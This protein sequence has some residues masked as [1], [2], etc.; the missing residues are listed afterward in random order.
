MKNSFKL[1]RYKLMNN[2]EKLIKDTWCAWRINYCAS[3]KMKSYKQPPLSKN[4]VIR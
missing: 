2:D 4:D 1:N 3:R